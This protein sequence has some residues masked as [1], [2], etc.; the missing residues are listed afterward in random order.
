M[1]TWKRTFFV[2][3]VGQAFSLVGS[4][5][6]HFAIA[7]WLTQ[8]T[9]SAAVLATMAIFGMIPQV[10]LG[11]F[12][13]ALVDRWNRRR[14][15]IAADGLIALITLWLAVMFFLGRAEIWFLYVTA[16]ARGTLGIFHW[17]AMQA[18][19][20]LMVP[21]EH[22][23]RVAGMNQTLQ[24][25][26]NIAAP[27]LGALLVGLLPLYGIMF[28]DVGTAIIAILPLFFVRIPQPENASAE[29]VTPRAVLRDVREGLRYI[30]SWPGVMMV[31][32]MAAMINFL[33]SP[34]GALTPLLVTRHFN[35]GVWHLSAVESSYSIG[36]IIGGLLLSIWGG[37][38]KRIVTSMVFLVV[39]GVSSLAIGLMPS[40]LFWAAIGFNLLSGVTNP[41]V[42]GPLFAMLQDRISP[43]M[44][45]RVFT[46]TASFSGMMAPL[47]MAL[48]APV[49]DRLG[50]QVWWQIGGIV[51][52]AMALGSFMI[53]A[54]MNIETDMPSASLIAKNQPAPPDT[55]PAG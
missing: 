17:T 31:L 14:V 50:I 16:L 23:S 25:I 6:I 13:G 30:A 53:P 7:W 4:Q 49:A 34:T 55:S 45:G 47:G 32:A 48:A 28:I 18:S 26:L 27:P 2:I 20:S 36:V 19:T 24:G 44:Q 35:G 52:L 51:T 15:M 11:P 9:G 3:W 10:V 40:W 42:N 37:Y 22:L 33:L 12:I 46:L 41:L 38:K 5:M 39:M 43:E 8:E 21:K 54:I 29:L 1:E